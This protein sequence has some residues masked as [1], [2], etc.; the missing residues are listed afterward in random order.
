MK[1]LKSKCLGLVKVAAFGACFSLSVAAFAQNFVFFN[2]N[3]YGCN[4]GYLKA[5]VG[6]LC[7]GGYWT[8]TN[9]ISGGGRYDYLSDAVFK[10]HCPC[11]GK[12]IIQV[13][14]PQSGCRPVVCKNTTYY[15]NTSWS[16]C[17]KIWGHGSDVHC[18]P[19]SCR[20]FMSSYKK[21]Y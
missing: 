10:Y 8:S 4:G 9:W 5:K 14:D 17:Y 16:S 3:C 2:T 19:T 20:G 7:N 12:I 1:T 6:C 21:L 11:K 13:Q 15:P 18:A